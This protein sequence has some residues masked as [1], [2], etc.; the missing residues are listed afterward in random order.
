MEIN[1]NSAAVRNGMLDAGIGTVGREKTADS[2]NMARSASN[3]TIDGAIEDLASSE[4]VSDVPDGALDRD[5]ALGRLVK[6]AFDFQPPPM[7]SFP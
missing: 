7:P 5:D 4:P 3:L 2:S 1:L 6:R